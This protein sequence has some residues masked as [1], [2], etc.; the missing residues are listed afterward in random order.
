MQLLTSVGRFAITLLVALALVALSDPPTL[1]VAQNA[2]IVVVT[3]QDTTPYQEAV[4]GFRRHLSEQQIEG[5]ILISSLQAEPLQSRQRLSTA[6]KEGVRLILT[7]GSQATQLA[8]KEAGDTPVIA[9]MV[10]NSDE[11]RNATNATGVIVDFPIEIHLRWLQRFLPER[12]TVGVLYNPKENRGRVEEAE[13]VARALGLKLVARPVDT[14][15]L[16]PDALHS[17]ANDTDVLWGLTDQTVLSPQTAEP[18][19]LFSF[20]NRIPFTGLSL[21]WVKAGALYALDRD[22]TDLGMQCG[23]LA[24]KV[25]QGARAGSLPLIAPRK[26]TYAINLKTAQ[27]MK[28]EITPSLIEGARQVFQ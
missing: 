18:I 8:L 6:T 7:V 19:L 21:S 13:R 9:C 25:L 22:Y 1:G 12:K 23:E 28:V 16:L 2:P 5:P 15:Q 14:P 17:L 24:V 20:R 11:L 27:H 10:V 4:A 26:V 3:S